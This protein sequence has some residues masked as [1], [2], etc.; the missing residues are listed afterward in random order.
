MLSLR[1]VHN[2]VNKFLNCSAR[3]CVRSVSLRTHPKDE[4]R[5]PRMLEKRAVEQSGLGDRG[6][7]S[8]GAMRMG[9]PRRAGPARTFCRFVMLHPRPRNDNDRPRTFPGRPQ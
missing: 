4:L 8:L 5:G 6:S 2:F 1:V 7:V 3:L 9:L